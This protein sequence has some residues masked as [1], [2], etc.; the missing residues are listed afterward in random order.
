MQRAA[1]V[2]E[3]EVGSV[4]YLDP[5]GHVYSVD[6]RMSSRLGHITGAVAALLDNGNDT[7]RFFFEGLAAVLKHHYGV[8]KV[9]LTTKF[10]STK[11]AGKEFIQHM[12]AEADFLV[13]GVAL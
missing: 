13:A 1:V 12:A 2:T 9:I 8:S 3:P 11:P 6:R 7:S 10:T 5:R 4:V